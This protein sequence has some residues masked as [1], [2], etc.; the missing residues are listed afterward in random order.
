MQNEGDGGGGKPSAERRVGT[1]VT[2]LDFSQKI[3]ILHVY[4]CVCVCVIVPVIVVEQS[5][6]FAV[7]SC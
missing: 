3:G 6:T 1:N 7:R 4:V 2:T 5:E